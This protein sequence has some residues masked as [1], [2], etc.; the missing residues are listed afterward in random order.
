MTSPNLPT[1]T[2]PEPAPATGAQGRGPSKTRNA[3]L[4][5]MF[6]AGAGILAY[7]GWSRPAQLRN[8]WASLTRPLSPALMAADT[9]PRPP[10]DRPPWDG[11]VTLK[12]RG[13][14]SMGIETTNVAPQTDPIRLELLGTSEYDSET[15]SQIRFMFKGR[16]DKVYK[17]VG[18]TVKKGDPLIDLYSTELAETKSAYEIKR[19]Q[20]TYDKNLLD[21]RKLLVQGQSIAQQLFAETQNSEMKSRREYEVA[22]DNLLVYGLSEAEVEEVKGQVGSQKARMTLRSPADGIII[23]RDVVV[24]NLYDEDDTLLVIAPLDHLWV[25]GNVFE[26]DID[27]VHLGQSWEVHFPFLNHKLVGKVEYISNRVDPG[28]HAV[29]IRTSVPNP[30]GRLKADMLVRGLLDVPPVA[31]WTVIPRTALVV[32]DRQYYVFVKVSG[33]A[34]KYER[35]TVGVAQEKEDH[36]VVETGLRAGEEIVSVGSLLVAQLY[37]DLKTVQT[38]APIGGGANVD[39][40]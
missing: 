40:R 16:V 10:A 2:P 18:Q 7:L 32:A 8:L 33:Q 6:L 17:T 28:T 13:R 14:A 19:I 31:G 34:D 12:E 3:A 30:E 26:S 39:E 11:L 24:G 37:D 36:V 38:G 9:G 20:W 5:A 27:L 21:A 23:T 25:W 29:R 1:H 4:V 35:R 22:R 15:L